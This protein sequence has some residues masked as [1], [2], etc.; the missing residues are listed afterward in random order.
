MERYSFEDSVAVRTP[1]SGVCDGC[2]AEPDEAAGVK[3]KKCTGCSAVLYC[4]K[5]CQIDAW[6]THRSMCRE[7]SKGTTTPLGYSSTAS[8]ANALKRWTNIHVWTMQTI[9]DATAHKM[10]GGIDDHLENQHAIVVVLSPGKPDPSDPNN[11][12]KAFQLAEVSLVRKDQRE[13]LVSQWPYIES[14]CNRM[15]DSMRSKLSEDERRTFAGFI[16]AA[17][18]FETTGMVSFHQYPIYRLRAHG[19]G[20]SYEHPRT[21]EEDM[22]FNHVGYLCGGLI[23][24]G[25]VL[26]APGGDDNA[27]LPDTGLYKRVKKSWVWMR[28]EWK[29]DMM[30]TSDHGAPYESFAE[31]FT[32][33]HQLLAQRNY[34][35]E[36]F[37]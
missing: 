30:D 20:P 33:Y 27:P 11:P 31:M 9:I 14:I 15:G 32:R 8:V 17:F 26:R 3:L 35:D 37:A 10:G 5:K 28:S 22:L 1:L 13:F 4:S 36:L 2:R 7:Q 24:Q 12:A 23:N 21:A 19:S 25:M 29:W 16:P 18:H 6:P 34:D